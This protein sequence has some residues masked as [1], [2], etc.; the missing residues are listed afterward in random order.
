MFI[1]KALIKC[2][3]SKGF[4]LDEEKQDRTKIST[5]CTLCKD[6]PAYKH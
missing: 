5:S 1:P 3:V 2:N 4:G 6:S